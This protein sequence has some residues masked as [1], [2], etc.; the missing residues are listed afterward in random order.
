MTQSGS[1]FLAAGIDGGGTKTLA[2]VVDGTGTERGR[3]VAGSGN[4]ATVGAEQTIGNIELAVERALVEVGAGTRPR[5]A[6]I[7]LAGVDR[8]ADR[9]RLL[10]LLQPLAPVIE[11]GNDAELA[12]AALPEA[13]GVA[14]IAGTGAIALGR[15]ARNE[16]V[17]ASGWGHVF[18]DEGSGY[19]IG[20]RALQAA[21]QAADGRG[22]DTTLLPAVIAQWDLADAT[23]II[24]R[25][26]HRFD[27]GDIAGLA[28]T[29]FA[30]A[31]AGDTV[32]QRIVRSAADELT[33][34]VLAVAKQLSFRD[35][36]LPLALSGGLLVGQSD[37]RA[38]VLRRVKFRAPLGV[39]EVVHEPA[40]SAA[41]AALRLGAGDGDPDRG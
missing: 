11:L 3:G 22:S 1:E 40:L 34:A 30:R 8:P 17:R 28:T 10:P 13:R 20:R 39:V 2:I 19:D 5:A 36:G 6:W 32:A 14:L 27:P 31:S 41:R 21:A 4:Y 9:E 25:V 18:G 24:D 37:F 16:I 35:G 12:L 26:Y 15:D 7:G 29:V 33:R 38:M 23:G